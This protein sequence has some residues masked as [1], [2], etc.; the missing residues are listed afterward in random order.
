MDILFCYA[1]GI[2]N[3][4]P[5]LV[6]AILKSY[7]TDAGFVATA[8]DLNIEIYNKIPRHPEQRRHTAFV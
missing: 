7:A 8:I 2:F 6:L 1:P 4:C 3:F 5:I